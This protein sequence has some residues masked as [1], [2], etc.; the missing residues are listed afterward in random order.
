MARKHKKNYKKRLNKLTLGLFDTLI[1]I[2]LFTVFF[3]LSLIGTYKSNK[4]LS[5]VISEAVHLT[6]IVHRKNLKRTIYYL[7]T[8]GYLQRKEDYFKI[9]R[10]GLKRLKRNLPVYEQKR[11][12]DGILY[13]ITYD[14]PEERKR[15]RD[16]LRNYLKKLGCGMLQQSVWITPYNPKRLIADF[17]K[18]TGT[19]GL[20]LVSELREGSH[21]GGKDMRDVLG[22]VYEIKKINSEYRK[23]IDQV[24][25]GK[26]KKIQLILIYLSI[27]KKDPQLPFEL[28]RDNY[29]GEGAYYFYLKEL[30]RIKTFYPSLK[31][32]K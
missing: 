1:D 19:I 27:L 14:I 11:L 26:L 20:V 2:C 30:K 16:Y 15:F 6:K 25:K 29:L 24:E 22:E 5:G 23:F 17:V 4:D 28:M 13:L 32:S 12:W 3:K 8:K 21:I 31:P 10:F 18:Q 7:T 9:T